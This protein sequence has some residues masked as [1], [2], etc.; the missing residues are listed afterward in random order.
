MRIGLLAGLWL[1]VTLLAAVAAEPYVNTRF[2]YQIYVPAGFSTLAEADNGDG[3]TA[4]DGKAT[5]AVWGAYLVDG[6]FAQEVDSRLSGDVTDGWSISYR[7]IKPKHASWS[8]TRGGTILYVRV[9][10]LCN[11]AAGHFRIEY[12][13]A[14]AKRY[15][16]AVSAFVKSFRNAADCP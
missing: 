7:S 11:D 10:A 5:L 8:G 16:E 13:K 6:N 9:I 3:G 1:S 15:D 14:E 12:P 4:S 2:G